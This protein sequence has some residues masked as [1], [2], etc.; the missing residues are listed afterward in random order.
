MNMGFELLTKTNPEWTE[1]VINNMDDFLI[2][3]AAC[4]RKASTMAMSM[5]THY[6]DKKELVIAMTDLAL[7]ELNHFRQVMNFINER[8]LIIKADEKDPYVNALRVHFKK[9]GNG[10]FL[11][12]LLL[13]SIIEKRGF[14]RFFLVAENLPESKLKKFYYAISK[15]E[16]KHY[17]LFLDLAT[18]YFPK[19]AIQIRLI[20]LLEIEAK[21]VDGLTIR[22]ALH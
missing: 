19:E 22:P 21:I 8:N 15:S 20:E 2:D 12:R 14:E 4:E 16:E 6:P 10:Y 5:L 17:E 3:H 13:A 11:D 7:E 1:T 9:D 18:Q